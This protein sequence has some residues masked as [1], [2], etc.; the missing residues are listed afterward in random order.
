MAVEK[1][2][3]KQEEQRRWKANIEDLLTDAESH[4]ENGASVLSKN[5]EMAYTPHGSGEKLRKKK[6]TFFYGMREMENVNVLL[7]GN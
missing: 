5:E 6:G 1:I 3:G 4:L 2:G 7:K